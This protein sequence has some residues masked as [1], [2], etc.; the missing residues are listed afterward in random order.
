M[1]DLPKQSREPEER[2]PGEGAEALMRTMRMGF[3][4][5]GGLIV[6]LVGIYVFYRLMIRNNNQLLIESSEFY[7]NELQRDDRGR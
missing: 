2:G 3:G 6:L 5:L 7:S 1:A 4:M